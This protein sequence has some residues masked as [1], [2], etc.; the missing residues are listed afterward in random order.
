MLS[1]ERDE[2][3]CEEA[4]TRVRNTTLQTI[5]NS[6]LEGWRLGWKLNVTMGEEREGDRTITFV[7]G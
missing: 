2:E 7:K 6:S 3:N 5:V 4:R 1:C